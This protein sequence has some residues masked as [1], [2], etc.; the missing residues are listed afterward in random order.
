MIVKTDIVICVTD[1]NGRVPFVVIRITIFFLRSL[2]HH[3]LLVGFVLL[4][5]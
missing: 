3:R 1:D 4:N 2:L 5:L